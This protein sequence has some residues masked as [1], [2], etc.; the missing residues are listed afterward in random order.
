MRQFYLEYKANK[1]LQPLDGEIS[2][3]KNVIMGG[4]L[5]TLDLSPNDIIPA[6]GNHDINLKIASDTPVPADHNSA[7]ELLDLDSLEIMSVPF[8]VFEDFCKY[9]TGKLRQ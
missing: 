6:P 7:D 9:G 5:K 8:K 3:T 2:W 4:L 1:K